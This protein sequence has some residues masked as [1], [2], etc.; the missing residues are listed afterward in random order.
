VKLSQLLSSLTQT[1][2]ALIWI[3]LTNKTGLDN[4][5]SSSK[6]DSNQIILIFKHS[7]R[8]G[9][10]MIAKKEFEKHWKSELPVH[11]VNVV[12]NREVSNIIE[13]LYQVKH[14]SPQ[15]LLIRNG[16]CIYNESHYGI[17]AKET[18]DFMSSH[19][20]QYPITETRKD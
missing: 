20:I 7:T 5:N 6:G 11:L 1:H 9:T 19:Y 12:E 16:K 17:D 14:E 15:L 2:K 18:M 10:S 8:C 3:D 13:H 4:L